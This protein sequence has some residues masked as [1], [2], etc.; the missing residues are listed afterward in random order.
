V[1]DEPITDPEVSPHFRLEQTK[2]MAQALAKGDPNA[3]RV[4]KR[5]LKG[6]LQEFHH[7]LA[8]VDS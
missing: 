2:T 1:V 4:F 3:V 6:K 7:S 5:L 8:K